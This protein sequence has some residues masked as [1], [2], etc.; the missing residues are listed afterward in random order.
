MHFTQYYTCISNP[1]TIILLS[2]QLSNYWPI[3][4]TSINCFQT[5]EQISNLNIMKHLEANNTLCEQQYGFC[6]SH[7]SDTLLITLL[8]D[9]SHFY[10]AGIQTDLIFTNFAKA[11]DMVPHKRLLYKLGWYSIRGNIKNWISSLLNKRVVQMVFPLLNVRFQIC[12]VFFRAQSLTLLC[13]PS[14]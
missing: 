6:H 2:Q 12:L 3:S 5:F 8:H 11:F 7:S 9:L 10:D 1:Y 4:L 14:T 13:F